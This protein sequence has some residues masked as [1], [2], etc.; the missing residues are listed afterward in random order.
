MANGFSAFLGGALAA[1]PDIQTGAQ[2]SVTLGREMTRKKAEDTAYQ[3]LLKQIESD[4]DIVHKAYE[5]FKV[6]PVYSKYF[7]EI[8]GSMHPSKWE[9]DRRGFFDEMAKITK[10]INLREQKE[11]RKQIGAKTQQLLA[12]QPA[13][14]PVEG[15]PGE[16]AVPPVTTQTGLIRGVQEEFPGVTK[17]ELEPTLG[18]LGA[19]QKEERMREKEAGVQERFEERQTSIQE[20]RD[21]RYKLAQDKHSLDVK[22]FYANL[23]KSAE[24]NAKTYVSDIW[25]QINRLRTEINKDEESAADI[26]KSVLMRDDNFFQERARRNDSIVENLVKLSGDVSIAKITQLRDIS[27]W[28]SRIMA[29]EKYTG[30]DISSAQ[31]GGATPPPKERPSIT[32]FFE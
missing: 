1:A 25:K 9:T 12:G 26:S 14:P 10:D 29:G 17:Q 7:S 4:K 31:T 22:K 3:Q 24:K 19:E 13:T 30:P 8:A 15:A 18:A 5:E 16:E 20:D 21:R 28:M 27:G 2:R 23:G 6:H 11:R 32:S